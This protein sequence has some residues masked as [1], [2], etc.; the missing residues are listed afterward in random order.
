[1]KRDVTS[2]NHW[3]VPIGLF[4]LAGLSACLAYNSYGFFYKAAVAGFS[5]VAILW[6]YRKSVPSN[7]DLWFIIAAFVFSVI[8]D[9]FLSTRSEDG[10]RF[11]WGIFFFFLA[12]LGYLGYSLRN[13]RPAWFFTL[14]VLAGYLTFYILVLYPAISDKALGLASLL[15]L[16]ISCISL[17]AAVGTRL[18][19]ASKYFLIL[20]IG[21]ILFSDTIIA[22]EEFVKYRDLNFLILPTYYLAQI[23]IAVSVLLKDS[24]S[25]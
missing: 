21:L 18:S 2:Q 14:F 9:W 15:Y 25:A 13:G 7:R 5:G 12:H 6:F 10:S 1:M 23:S 11:L 19:L 8:G 20:G 24:N 22:F 4:I 17:G 3:A 16:F